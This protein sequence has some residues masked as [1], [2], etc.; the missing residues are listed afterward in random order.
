MYL[1][2]MYTYRVYVEILLRVDN[3]IDRPTIDAAVVVQCADQQER[4]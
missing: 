2:M 1:W 3:L 4:K